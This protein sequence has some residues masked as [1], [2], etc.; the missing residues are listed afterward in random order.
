MCDRLVPVK[1]PEKK[2][3]RNKFSLDLK[4]DL[5]FLS[6]FRAAKPEGWCLPVEQLSSPVSLK[7]LLLKPCQ[8]KEIYLGG[9]KGRSWQTI[10]RFLL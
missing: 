9:L 8:S 7:G 4:N 5:S 10:N 2:N 3:C 1:A 6:K